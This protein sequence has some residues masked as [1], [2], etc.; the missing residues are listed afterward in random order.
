LVLVCVLL[1]ASNVLTLAERAAVRFCHVP[2]LLRATF[3][4]TCKNMK[5]MY[6]GLKHG[7]LPDDVQVRTEEHW[8]TEE[9]D[10]PHRYA[11]PSPRLASSWET[12]NREEHRRSAGRRTHLYHLTDWIWGCEQRGLWLIV[13]AMQRRDYR[14]AMDVYLRV[15]I[16]NA[17]WPIGVTMVGEPVSPLSRLPPTS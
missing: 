4:L 16:G 3:D 5:Y 9:A 6:R 8:R 10:A 12:G 7:S 2:Q 14:D 11:W 1:C 13:E 17:P 15:S